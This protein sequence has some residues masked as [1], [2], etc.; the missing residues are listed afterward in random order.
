MIV[1][2]KDMVPFVYL[3]TDSL[4]PQLASMFYFVY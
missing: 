2:I 1:E 3:W 4:G